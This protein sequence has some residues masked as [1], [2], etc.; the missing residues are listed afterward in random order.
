MPKV[1][2]PHCPSPAVRVSLID[3]YKFY[4]SRCGWNH[5]TVQRELSS[6]T[7]VSLVLVALGVI[8]AIVVRI[9][10]PGESWAW[11][12]LVAFAGLPVYYA[13]SAVLQ[14]RK[15]RSM[16]FQP[17]VNQ[18]RA[19]A[20]SEM[21]ASGAPS[22]TTVFEDREFPE[23][24]RVL[25]PR[26]L[27]MT[28]KGRFYTAFA[29]VVV[30]LFTVYGLPA[31]WSEFNNPRSSQGRNWFLVALPIVIYGYSFVFFRNRIRER[32]LLANGELA[33]GYVTAQNNR[34][35]THSVQYCFKLSEGRLWFGRCNDASRSLYEGMTVP[36][37]Y[38]PD[39]PTHSI[40]LDCSL[41]TIASS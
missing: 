9:K 40:P 2:C 8:F 20:I 13:L 28:W 33:S 23:L 26:E 21:S 3:G 36:V 6:A 25:R 16:S 31:F 41:T 17:V 12:I 11:A 14:M 32:Q 37:F 34:R 5:E 7:T 38:D 4:C 27:R 35:Y 10:N 15:L 29:L 19:I 24:A 1:N 18:S 30:C 22:K 39:K